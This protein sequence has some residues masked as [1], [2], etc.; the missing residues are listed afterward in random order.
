VSWTSVVDLPPRVAAWARW[1]AVA[2][3]ISRAATAAAAAATVGTA[4]RRSVAASGSA[5][6]T[7]SVS[8][9]RSTAPASTSSAKAT[10]G[11]T[12]HTTD[13][14]SSSI[15]TTTAS[16]A[17]ATA[18]AATEARALTSDALEEGGDF[19]VGLLEQLEEITDDTAVATVEEGGCD[20]G[21]SGTTSTTD[22]MNVIV[23]VGGQI[24]V[25][26]VSD[27]INIQTYAAVS[28]DVE[29]V[30]SI[31]NCMKCVPECVQEL[32]TSGGVKKKIKTCLE[33]RQQLQPEWGNDQFGTSPVPFHAHAGC[34]RR[35]WRWRGN[36]G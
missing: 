2:S 31:K 34:G 11:T 14:A 20:T 18:A 3:T 19:L 22:T 4:S 17:T 16:T 27:I 29:M 26:D 5:A 13:V 28:I 1:V 8:T 24:V 15:A 6:V 25:D 23:N 12:T 7:T 36:P 30:K 21:V 33:Q 35:G 32:R 9:L 10:A